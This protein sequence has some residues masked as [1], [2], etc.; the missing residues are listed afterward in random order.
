MLIRYDPDPRA[1]VD[2]ALSSCRHKI[3]EAYGEA[4][5]RL[6]ERGS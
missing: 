5:A 4:L 2:E 6:Y 1:L 3:R